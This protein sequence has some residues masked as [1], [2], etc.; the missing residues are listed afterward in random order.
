MGLLDGKNGIIFGIANKRSIAWAIA[1]A[2]GREGARLAL[3]YQGER[4]KENVEELA[5]KLDKPAI[6]PCDVTDD[7]QIGSVFQN[8][9]EEFGQLDF[10]IHAVAYA[11]RDDLEGHFVNT[12]REGY[13]I[14]QDHQ[15]RSGCRTRQ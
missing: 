8:L 7:E 13:R 12:S 14:A 3:T 11:L 1:Q 2:V 5:E 10:I 15:R 4:L 9:K 6:L